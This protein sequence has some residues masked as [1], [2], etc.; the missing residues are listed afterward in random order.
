MCK[1]IDKWYDA[2]IEWRLIRNYKRYY[3]YLGLWKKG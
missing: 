1:W 3:T 2:W